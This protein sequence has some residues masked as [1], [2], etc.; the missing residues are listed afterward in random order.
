MLFEGSENFFVLEV[1]LFVLVFVAFSVW[2]ISDFYRF[3]KVE[4]KL[5]RGI[6]V[7]SRQLP[8]NAWLAL[9]SMKADFIEPNSSSVRPK[10]FIRI[11][12]DEILIFSSPEKSHSSWE[13]VGY[14]E[15][16]SINSKLQYRMS[17]PGIIFLLLGNIIGI[18]IFV[19]SFNMYKRAID[20]FLESR[21]GMP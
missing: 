8:N 20:S 4:G 1:L 6:K 15:R 14:V 21:V 16:S 7:W 2:M 17:L 19:L 18:V 5:K 10:K 11:H 3:T 13:C 12:D 9:L